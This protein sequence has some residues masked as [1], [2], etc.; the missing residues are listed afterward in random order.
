M[1]L[2]DSQSAVFVLSQERRIAAMIEGMLDAKLDTLATRLENLL[3]EKVKALKNKFQNL[4]NEIADWKDDYNCS[5]D[6]V[7]RDLHS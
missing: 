1:S 3:N 2:P 5:L 4:E 7:E 6:H